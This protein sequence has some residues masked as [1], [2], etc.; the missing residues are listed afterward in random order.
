M[1]E[2]LW[3]A[4]VELARQYGVHSVSHPLRLDYMGLKKRL[5]GVADLAKEEGNPAGVC[6][7]DQFSFDDD[8]GVRDRVR[9]FD[10]KQDAD[11]VERF[12][13]T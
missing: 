2:A 9:V 8:L 10:R 6:R 4:A 1:P 7:A 5:A 11:S 13:D 12:L 3:Q